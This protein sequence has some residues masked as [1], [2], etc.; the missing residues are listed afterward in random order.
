MK[1]IKSL[2]IPSI[3]LFFLVNIPII[4]EAQPWLLNIDNKQKQNFYEIQRSFNDYWKGRNFK[5]KGKGWKPYKRWEW[6]WEQRVY[7]SGAFPNGNQ[8]IIEYKKMIRKRPPQK[9]DKQQ[10][11]GNWVSLGPS[12][13]NGGY[14]GLG[15]VNVVRQHPNNSNLLF[16]GAAS[17][18]LWKST[19]G[20]I[21]W[22]TSTDDLAAIGITDI[23]F[24]SSNANIMYLA[25]GD[26][27][28]A[29]TYSIGVLIST[30]GGDT[31]NQTGL[32]WTQNQL[33][34][35]SRLLINPLYP[36]ILYASGNFGIYKT[37][38]AGTNWTQVLYNNIKDMEF[39]PSN[40]SIIYASGT[41]IY[42][43]INDGTDWNLLTSNLPST[44]VSRIAL[45]VTQAD[46]NFVYA[47]ISNNSYGFLGLYRST[48]SGGN[49]DLMADTTNS[50][51]PNILGWSQNGS[52]SGG[53]GWY[54]L[55]LAA[56][57]LSSNEIYSGGINV[58]KST[59]GG[60]NWSPV[61]NWTSNMHADIHDLWFVPGSNILYSGCDGG[62]YKTTNSGSTWN[63][64]GNTLA[65]TQYYKLSNSATNPNLVIAGSQDNGTKLRNG[66]V[67]KDV[68][69]GDGMECIIDYTNPNI[70]YGE[71]YHGE[72]K[73]STNAG[74]SFN[75]INLPSE[76]NSNYGAWVTPFQIHPTHHN[77][78]YS[79]YR[80]I[81]KTTNG[82]IN[83]T[84]LS[85][86][87]SGSLTVLNI[88]PSDSNT[89]YASTGKNFWRSTN[90]GSSWT[91]LLIPKAQLYLT[92]LAI[93]QSNPKIIWASFSGYSEG[94]KVFYSTDGGESWTN[95]S[96]SLPNV[97]VNC[98]I[99]Q[100]NFYDRI[101]AATDIGVFYRDNSTTD[102]IDFSTSLPNVPV[103][104]IEIQYNA[105]KLRAATYGRGLWETDIPLPLIITSNISSQVVCP[106]ANINISFLINRTFNSGNV[107]T[108][109]IS[110]SIGDFSDPIYIGSLTSTSTGI[111]SAVIPDSIIAGV[112][113]KVR[114]I[115]S[116]PALIGLD[117]G[118]A[119]KVAP[120]ITDSIAQNNLL[121]GDSLKVPFTI[122][123]S[124]SQDNIFTAVLSD[125]T[126]NFSNSVIIG[127]LQGT[128]SGVISCRLP[129]NTSSGNGYR[130]RVVSS[131]PYYL[132]LDNGSNINVCGGLTSESFDQLTTPACWQ[133]KQISS[134]GLWGFIGSGLHPTCKPHSGTGMAMFQS[135]DFD[136]ET[137]SDLISPPFSTD[138]TG[139]MSLTF[140][141]YRD[142]AYSTNLDKIDVYLNNK[143]DT[144]NGII[145]G[146]V[147]RQ[148][149]AYP[150][151]ALT[152]WY[153]YTYKLPSNRAS[154]TNYIIFKASS[155]WGNNIFIDDVQLI[156][157]TQ[158]ISLNVGWNMISSYIKPSNSNLDSIFSNLMSSENL[159]VAKNF[160]GGVFFPF[161]NY[162]GF[163]NWDSV[164]SIVVNI[165]NK[166]NLIIKGSPL[167]PDSSPIQLKKGWNYLPYLRTSPLPA[168]KALASISSALL[169]LKNINNE[170]YV[171]S[172]YINNLES[173]TSNQGNMLP[174]KGYMVYVTQDI[175][176]TYPF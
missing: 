19:N 55:C 120:I 129:V 162:Y 39:K 74:A 154:S 1:L 21:N 7:P 38:D 10:S 149:D 111:I 40:P 66:S 15:R 121:G 94:N 160:N 119:L 109:Q 95:K 29:D 175:V 103:N 173:G 9:Y 153:R 53:Q 110:N 146:T 123:C 62:V 118:I 128:S 117:N 144:I 93:H 155:Q 12:F 131:D 171:P 71:L 159:V 158:T 174:G 25:T 134:T 50:N 105:S 3:I 58:W 176:L 22:M 148:I 33:L 132:G 16:A 63:W 83:W 49:W 81:F 13:S 28:A 107:F 57:P 59:N 60:K 136:P 133:I 130:V 5:E 4:V 100:N 17:G 11:I 108:A 125:S 115:S 36:N 152:G 126:G 150:T 48:N 2:L 6:F 43:S 46:S 89:I 61:S 113:Y 122:I 26:R 91:S 141:M 167:F 157:N 169:I 97:P 44:N 98:I 24:S 31:W 82:G 34:T 69:G 102:W 166:D 76:Y 45:A 72:I 85:S 37:T 32:I 114:I 78:L 47:L 27:D 124:F 79:A 170:Q 151:V 41:S 52:D 65:I 145:L 73:K 156:S 51:K 84:K 80:N 143:P 86:F 138:E 165:L 135:Y 161:I 164:S 30:D 35:I 137:I 77:T 88:A 18:G 90:E 104:E 75:D 142:F 116:D 172:Q 64:I 112:G 68:I 20:G 163:Q 67:W 23:V 56:S 92:G 99:Y 70:M 140:W 54:D 139:N 168:D 96:G 127:S 147:N 106:G 14:A 87:Q 42:K 8:T 101:Y